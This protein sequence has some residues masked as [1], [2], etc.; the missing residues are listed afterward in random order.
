VTG[1]AII[2]TAPFPSP[3]RKPNALLTPFAFF[4]SSPGFVISPFAPLSSEL[5]KAEAP[6]PTP[7]MM[8]VGLFFKSFSSFYAMN[9]LSKESIARGLLTAVVNLEILPAVPP[10]EY[11]ASSAVPLTTPKV[12]STSPYSKPSLGIVVRAVNPE[13]KSFLS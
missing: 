10:T 8:P 11:F 3:F 7:S 13:P 12:P 6:F 5:P 4:A 2:P 9:P 1:L